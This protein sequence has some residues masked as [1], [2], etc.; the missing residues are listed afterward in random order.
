[1]PEGPL[2]KASQKGDV[3]QVRS[4]LASGIKP[5]AERS[6][7]NCTPLLVA[8]RD[9]HTDCVI[10]LVKAKA[11]VNAKTK[12]KVTPL[13]WAAWRGHTDIV[14]TLL[15]A[16]DNLNSND[17]YLKRALGW[18]ETYDHDDTVAVLKQARDDFEGFLKAHMTKEEKNNACR[19]EYGRAF[20]PASRVT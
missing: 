20:A 2:F 4:L 19:R 14:I 17:R 11:D 15:K 5:D 18:A 16:M 13:I 7:M 3:E 1:M 8:A 6:V 10:A 12:T 9:G